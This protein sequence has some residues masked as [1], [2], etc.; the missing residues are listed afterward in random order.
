MKQAQGHA[1]RDPRGGL[2]PLPLP[3]QHAAPREVAA[4]A[5]LHG[6]G[7]A[8]PTRLPAEGGCEV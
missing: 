4:Q 8:R 5:H 6:G 3:H 2:I 1:V 7:Q